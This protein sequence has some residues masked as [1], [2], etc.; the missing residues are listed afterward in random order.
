MAET[1]S[2]E[3]AIFEAARHIQPVDARQ[4]YLRQ[5]CGDDLALE[6]R[7]QALLRAYEESAT[8]LE[9][10]PLKLVQC[11]SSSNPS[12]RNQALRSGVTGFSSKLAKAGWVWS[13][14]PNRP[15]QSQEWW[16]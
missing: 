16:P 8:F 10:P 14:W 12:P 13:T 7:I 9:S 5:M 6:Q 11:R 3:Q 1:H 4:R 15:S 2:D